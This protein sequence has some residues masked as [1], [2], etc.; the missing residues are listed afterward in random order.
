MS[1]TTP[2]NGAAGD[3]PEKPV[4]RRGCILGLILTTVMISG[5]AYMF[6]TTVT[7][8]L[9]PEELRPYSSEEGTR[10]KIVSDAPAPG[11]DAR[12]SEADLQFYLG[13]L[14]TI[15]KP[16][17][18]LRGRFDSVVGADSQKIDLIRAFDEF[19]QMIHLP[20]YS[21]RALVDYLNTQR[22][23]WDQYLWTKGRIVAASGI[24]Q[25]EAHKALR[26]LYGE[27]FLLEEE[28]KAM[29][30][31]R[32]GSDQFYSRV[33]S[34]RTAGV[35]SS[36]IALVRPYHDTLLTKGLHSLMGIETMF[37]EE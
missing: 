11:G 23:S 16:W 20:F 22:V 5:L 6:V 8:M 28:E 29:T 18:D 36:E 12:L 30:A 24:T 27:Y 4:M 26:D 9:P 14:N 37:P 7:D 2:N 31:I 10:E 21:R 15:D 32:E 3:A 34:I 19:K 1:D 33:D 17:Q 35:D 25:E 13:A